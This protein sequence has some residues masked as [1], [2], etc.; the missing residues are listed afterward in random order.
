VPVVLLL[1]GG[2]FVTSANVSA[3]TDLRA[4]RY[5]DLNSLVRQESQDVAEL[6]AEAERLTEQVR[7]LTA[8]VADKDVEEAQE[9][10]AALRQPAGLVAMEGPGLTVTLDDAPE[11]EIDALGGATDGV[12]PSDLVVHQQDI[13]AVANALWAGGADAMTIQGQRVISTTGIKCVG[14]T[15]VL[16]GVPYSPPY[17]ISAIGD[18]PELLTSINTDPYIRIY[19]QYAQA[20]QLGYEVDPQAH[21]EVPGYDGT[22]DLEYARAAGGDDRPTVDS[23]L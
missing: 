23:D 20:H 22:L 13:Q 7:R 19:R 9:R 10:V 1:A 5:S 3:G 15:V 18:P 6:R 12:R 2:L 11:A 17:V 21:L 16:H 14:N 8:R 4:G